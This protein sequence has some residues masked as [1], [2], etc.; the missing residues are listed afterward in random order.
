MMQPMWH[1]QMI[2]NRHLL[3]TLQH[4]A[5]GPLD[6]SGLSQICQDVTDHFIEAG[7]AVGEFY[8]DVAADCLDAMV[9]HPG[10]TPAIVLSH[11]VG[12]QARLANINVDMAQDLFGTAGTR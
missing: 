7:L 6:A 9:N 4:A 5:P 10:A 12:L 1:V 3:D 2:D 11:W 8:R